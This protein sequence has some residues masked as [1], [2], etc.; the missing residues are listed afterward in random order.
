MEMADQLKTEESAQPVTAGAEEPSVALTED[1]VL[2]QLK[3]RGLAREEI[4]QIGQNAAA[5]KSRKV[6]ISLAAHPRTPRRIALRLIREL[7]TFD[8][9]AFAMMPAALA[10]LKRVADEALVARLISLTLGERISLARRGSSRVAGALLLD[11]EEQ[12]WRPALENPRLIEAAVVKAVNSDTVSSFVAAVSH[13]AKWSLRAEVRIA[14]LCS[15]Y[16]PLDQA[17]D[18]ARSIPPVQLRDILQVSRL[19]TNIKSHLHEELL[20]NL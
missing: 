16:T 2:A 20:P 14:L 5:M 10:D 1:M 11:K 6:R 9:M 17:L 12:V 8:L 18:F 4:E 13:H 15:A 19:P 7:H 3:D